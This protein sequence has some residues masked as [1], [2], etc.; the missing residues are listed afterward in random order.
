MIVLTISSS[1]C[2]EKLTLLSLFTWIVP[3]SKKLLI[4]YNKGK[5]LACK[6][7]ANVA[8]VRQPIDNPLF[9]RTGIIKLPS[10]SA[11]PVTQYGFKVDED[12]EVEE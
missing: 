2:T 10:A 8:R 3:T 7:I 6:C 11:N 4:L 5:S 1:F 9:L 12:G